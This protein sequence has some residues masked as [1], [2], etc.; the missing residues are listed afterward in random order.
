M[1]GMTLA[2]ITASDT[3]LLDS[4]EDNNDKTAGGRNLGQ[5]HW[6]IVGA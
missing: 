3:F 4:A 2:I 1:Q 5:G 6:V